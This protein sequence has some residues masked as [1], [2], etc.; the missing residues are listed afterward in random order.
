MRKRKLLL[1]SNSKN[2]GQE[3]LE[4]AEDAITSFLGDDIRTALFVPF[5][6]VTISWDDFAAKVCESFSEL[7]YQV[8]ALHSRSD[9][10]EAVAAA[11]AIVVGGGN[12]FHLLKTLYDRD[13]LDAIRDRVADGAPYIGW[14]AGSNVACP[15]IR[16]TND[17]P[18]VEPPSLD[19]LGLVP[20][21]INPHYTNESLPHHQGETRDDRLAEFVTS[22][23]SMRIVGLREG[24]MLMV[25]GKEITVLGESRV[26]IFGDGPPRDI[27]G[28]SLGFLFDEWEEER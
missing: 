25:D 19:A 2:H 20:F 10:R 28:E 8:S 17:M 13:V 1:L 11:D 12:S 27:E 6:G 7:G 14:S 26:R 21:Q 22:N 4:H 5:A 16:T 23:P 18:I 9:S 3:F 15:T 24:S